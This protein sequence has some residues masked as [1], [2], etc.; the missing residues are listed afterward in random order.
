[1]K[2]KA[3]H[4]FVLALVAWAAVAEL[5]PL[6]EQAFS[7]VIEIGDLG[8]GVKVYLVAKNDKTETVAGLPRWEGR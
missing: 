3:T 2:R 8:A 7:P 4:L 5:R 1:M 6:A